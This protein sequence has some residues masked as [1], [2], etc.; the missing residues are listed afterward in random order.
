[1]GFLFFHSDRPRSLL[2]FLFY[3]FQQ[4]LN[5]RIASSSFPHSLLNPNWNQDPIISITVISTPYNPSLKKNLT[6]PGPKKGSNNIF[7][8]TEAQRKFASKA[9][10]P[11]D[12][13]ELRV[14]V[15]TTFKFELA[16][17]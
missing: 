17:S 15:R 16:S 6:F 13:E 3:W 11:K 8:F 14:L 2:V 10:V 12:L 5:S 7:D 4:L 9:K 1:M